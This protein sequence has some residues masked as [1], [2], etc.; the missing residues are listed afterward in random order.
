M[1]Y[2]K[3]KDID[4]SSVCRDVSETFQ[5]ASPTIQVDDEEST[6]EHSESG[7]WRKRTPLVHPASATN[8][9]DVNEPLPAPNPLFIRFSLRETTVQKY[10]FWEIVELSRKVFTDITSSFCMVSRN[11]LTLGASIILSCGLLLFIHAYFK[12][13]KR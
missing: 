11:P 13:I 2:P 10:W 12:P 4:D 8:D 7:H 9:R 6:D 1:Y 5:P 3:S